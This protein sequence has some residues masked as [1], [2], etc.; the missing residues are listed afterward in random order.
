[1]QSETSKQPLSSKANSITTDINT[2]TEKEIAYNEFQKS[3]VKMINELKEETQKIVS[4]L[5]EDV[6]K[7][8]MAQRAYKQTDE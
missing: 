1:M 4:D 7:Q 6:N 5:K 3:I 8:K 2:C